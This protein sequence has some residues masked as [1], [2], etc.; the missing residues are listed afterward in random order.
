MIPCPK[1]ASQNSPWTA[2]T[3]SAATTKK[4]AA[5][6]DVT[7]AEGKKGITTGAA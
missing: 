3:L 2:R 4:R 1:P 5:T 7:R 6:A